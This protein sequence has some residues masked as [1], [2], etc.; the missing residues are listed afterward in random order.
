MDEITLATINNAVNQTGA[1]IDD[2]NGRLDALH[3]RCSETNTTLRLLITENNNSHRDLN[4]K[5]DQA[6]RLIAN[7][8]KETSVTSQKVDDHLEHHKKED[9]RMNINGVKVTSMIG[10]F[11]SALVGAATVLFTTGII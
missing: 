10:S 1:R 2:I 8:E 9:E 5:I 11:G 6:C 3:E 7:V 4:R